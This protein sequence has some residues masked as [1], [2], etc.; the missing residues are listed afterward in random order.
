MKLLPA[1]FGTLLLLASCAPLMTRQESAAPTLL[2]A[3]N[4]RTYCASRTT[5]LDFGLDYGGDVGRI[6]VYA[7][8]AGSGPPGGQNAG[9]FVGG[10][11]DVFRIGKGHVSGSVALQ[12]EVGNVRVVPAGGASAAI[13]LDPQKGYDLYFRAFSASGAPSD[14]VPGQTVTPDDGVTCDPDLRY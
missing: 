1:L 12:P 2:G 5:Y 11:G 4:Q 13:S 14:F 6:E 8:E 7:T 9:R 10:G 3:Q